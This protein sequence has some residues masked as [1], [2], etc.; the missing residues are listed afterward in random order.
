VRKILHRFLAK[1]RNGIQHEASPQQR[2]VQNSRSCLHILINAVA[3]GFSLPALAWFFSEGTCFSIEKIST[4]PALTDLPDKNNEANWLQKSTVKQLVRNMNEKAS[5]R[6]VKM[7]TYLI[8]TNGIL[9][10]VYAK[11]HSVNC[12][13][14]MLCH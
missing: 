6:S 14:R 9:S 4:A 7:L 8:S 2:K 12:F 3:V 5:L 1:L 13:L 10:L 11:H